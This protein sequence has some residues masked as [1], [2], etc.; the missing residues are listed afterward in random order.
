ML[1]IKMVLKYLEFQLDSADSGQSYIG[2]VKKTDWPLFILGGKKPLENIAGFKII[3]AQIP[4]SWYV[5]NR[6]NKTF[7][8]TE[9]A[10]APVTVTLVEGNYNAAD[11]GVMLELALRAASL[12]GDTYDVVYD[13]APM[14]FKIYN[15]ANADHPFS[16]TFGGGGDSGNANPRIVMGFNAGSIQ[17]QTYEVGGPAPNG[18]VLAAPNV[19]QV[20]GPNYVYVNSTSIGTL[21]DMYLPKGAV[22]LDKGNS[23]P[24]V[25]KIPVTVQPGGVIYWS[26]P[27][28][29]KYFDLENLA[30]LSQIDFYLT[31]GNTSAMTPL[32]LNGLSFSLKIGLLVKEGTVSETAASSWQNDRVIKRIRLQ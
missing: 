6:T 13:A 21:T 1:E 2:N 26:D 18:N 8:L 31:L 11:F 10:Q 28:P 3:E 23:G 32:E 4:F 19:C 30:N 17:S 7:V 9:D 15:D 22:N 16:L 24:Q 27:D 5:V 29:E 25:T 12:R 20:T 14:K